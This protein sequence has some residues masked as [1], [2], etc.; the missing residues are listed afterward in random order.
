MKIALVADTHWG[1]RNDNSIFANYF[2]TFF[3]DQFFPYLKQHN[4]TRIIHLGDVVDRR[5]YINY[6]THH[7]MIEYFFKPIIDNNIQLDV[8]V[9]NHDTYFKNTNHINSMQQ[10][11]GS[12]RIPNIRWYDNEP[13]EIEI[14]GCKIFLLPWICTNSAD[15][16]MDAV[17]NTKAQVL[18][19]HLELQG[20]EL[21]RGSICDHGYDPILFNKFDIVCS[22]HFHHRSSS[23]NINYLGTP[24]ELTWS[25]Y[26]DP[27]GFHIFDTD[28]RQLEFIHNPLSMFNK[29][30]YD[31]SNMTIENITNMDLAKYKN[32]FV[33]VIVKQKT[34][35]YWFDLFI[36]QLE[37]HNPGNVQIVEDNLSLELELD[38]DIVNEAEDTLTILHK[39]I[40]ALD[41]GVDKEKL[42]K[43]ITSLYQEALMV[44]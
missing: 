37:K 28:T 16:F 1:A 8:I 6:Q 12:M 27:R 38:D 31:D 35:P 9:G 33:K 32:T 39:Y 43:T 40:D 10:L 4:I 17:A 29:I 14:D 20:F 2:A 13:G 26:N 41:V 23:G 21:L 15:K 18:M 7:S 3:T 44:T 30:F 19:G 34:N 5:K 36:E 11:F 25:D 42:E 22:G 24:Y